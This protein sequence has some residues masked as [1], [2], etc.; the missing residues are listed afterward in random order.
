MDNWFILMCLFLNNNILKK[1]YLF[2]E[3]IFKPFSGES[4]DSFIKRKAYYYRIT[5]SRI[6]I[7]YR[8][9][10]SMKD[11]AI[12]ITRSEREEI[13]AFWAKYLTPKQRNLLVDYRFYDVY[14]GFQLE[15]MPLMKYIP[16]TFYY[17]FIDDYFTNPQNTAP[18]ENKILYDLYFHDV[19]MPKTIFR[20]TKYMYLDENYHEITQ[21]SAI[22]KA[23]DCCEVILKP[24]SSSGGK[25][26]L[27]WNSSND[28]KI[29][30]L[31]YLN[32]AGDIVCQETISQHESLSRINS[33]S[34]NTIRI[35]TLLFQGQVYVLSRVLRMGVDGA[36]VDNASSGGVVS[37][38]LPNGRI[39][40]FAYDLAA[41]KYLKHPNGMNFDCIFV[42][43]I[44]NC[45]H[46]SVLL[47]KRMSLISRLI[48]WDFA[49]DEAGGPILI[50]MNPTFGGLE[51]N[52]LTN[53]PILG[54]LTERVL[55]E[56]FNNSYTLNS[57]LKSM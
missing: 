13:D 19:K 49:I 1:K 36:R 48:S 24:A 39:R 22:S 6:S 45:V 35:V 8:K 2:M 4:E 50:E 40:N 38:I 18:F 15:G 27:F 21:S 14:K 3:D 25:G 44:D 26:V 56:V 51:L 32:Q 16:S 53:G 46:L 28:S 20:K 23:L 31:D 57:I 47:A 30:L 33:S 37:G 12:S 43:S 41:N 10:D 34:V 11:N 5:S 17:A 7:G 29:V 55:L 54:E 42:P 52:Q 9:L